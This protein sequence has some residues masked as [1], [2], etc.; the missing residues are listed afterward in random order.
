MA[1]RT[2]RIAPTEA[3]Q[4]DSIPQESQRH[5]S[6]Q[7][8]SLGHARSGIETNR[9]ALVA[10]R[11][12]P[13]ANDTT[14]TKSSQRLT[15]LDALAPHF[16][17]EDITHTK[18]SNAR[19]KL[20]MQGGERQRRTGENPNTDW[21]FQHNK[22]LGDVARETGHD[23][24]RVIAASAVMSPQNNPEQELTAVS[25]LA[26]M[27]ADP[28]ARIAVPREALQNIGKIKAP[29][30]M[31]DWVGREVHPSMLNSEQLA[32]LSNAALRDHVK[33]SGD[34][35]LAGVS[36]G[37]VKSNV[38]KA[39]DVLRG[40]TDL[41]KA[42]DPSSSPKVWS[43]HNN[44][45]KSVYGS[46]EHTE[47][48]ERMHVAT[49]GELK[50]QERMDLFGLRT[51]THGP[52]DPK[53]HTAEDTWQQAISTRQR[54][55]AVPVP[56]RQGRAA[57][58]SPAKF[59]VG[60]GGSANQKKLR[61]VPGLPGV[62]DSA[63]MHAWQNRATQMA[64]SR[65]SRESGEIIPSMGV[66]AGGWTEGRRQAGKAI[67]ENVKQTKVSRRSGPKQLSLGF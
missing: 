19:Y 51:A 55:A 50:G 43:Y 6:G 41:S 18:A 62:K 63:L 4:W 26:R 57:M 15:S 14:R 8:R 67:E 30:G 65:M 42:I 17:D 39:I 46:P 23:K 60:E 27:H 2:Q 59:T 61:A 49:G 35:D 44:I 21:Y 31:N 25:A 22:K 58:Q 24:A 48:S 64:A 20:T 56:G 54:L 47:F 13:K 53:G 32:H 10:S 9:A 37:G 45:A 52:L 3:L 34:V 29:H 66:Q 40:H 16:T 33:V 28:T 7:M 1:K 11:D 5:L 36:K 12:N 38:V